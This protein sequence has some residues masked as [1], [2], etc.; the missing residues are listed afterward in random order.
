MIKV[1]ATNKKDDI[2]TELP[3][4]EVILLEGELGLS[5]D[6][7]YRAGIIRF[8]TVDDWNYRLEVD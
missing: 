2:E 4:D 3:L 5:M 1:F 6:I 7:L 8:E